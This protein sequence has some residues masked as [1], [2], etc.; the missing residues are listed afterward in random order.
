VY[1]LPDGRCRGVVNLGWHGGKRRRKYIT[2]GTQAE[3]VRELRRLTAAAEVRPS[4]ITASTAR[5]R[6]SATLNSLIRECQGST[7]VGVNHQPKPCKASAEGETSSLSRRHTRIKSRLGESNPGPTHYECVALPAE[8]RRHMQHFPMGLRAIAHYI[9]T[10]R[11][12]SKSSWMR[13]SLKRPRPGP[14]E[15]STRVPSTGPWQL[16]H[17]VLFRGTT[18]LFR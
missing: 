15:N 6:C 16:Q 2:R 13:F 17:V 1:R 3:V 5:Y 14:F 7:E 12:L 9:E 11:R 4:L 18:F 10:G 8:L